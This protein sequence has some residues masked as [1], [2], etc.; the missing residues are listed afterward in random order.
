MPTRTGT[1]SWSPAMLAI[2]AA[3]PRRGADAALVREGP[4]GDG[5]VDG[6]RQSCTTS[7]RATAAPRS[8]HGVSIDIADGEF[9]VIVGPSGCGKSTLL[10]MVAGL[11]AITA[12]TIAIDG[13]VVNEPRAARARHRHGLPELRAL[14]AHERLRQ[15]GL[16]P[17][18]R[19][20]VRGAEIASASQRDRRACS[21]LDPLP[22]PQ[23]ARAFRRPAPARRHGPGAWCASRRPSSSTSRS[24][25]STPSCACR[26]A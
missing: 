1:S 6:D 9:I 7:A 10:R 21:E 14:P 17:A 8:I 2:A 22:R 16:R 19:R 12:G 11:E 4:R 23:A 24:P 3:D 25:I 20:H 5:E 15:H 18:H 13:R 26:C